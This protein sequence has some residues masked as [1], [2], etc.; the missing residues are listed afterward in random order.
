MGQA[1]CK[2]RTTKA[3]DSKSPLDRVFVRCA[4]RI[5]PSLKEEGSVLGGATQ[6]VTSSEIGYA[7]SPPR[8]I[9]ARGRSID[10]VDR[11]FHPSDWVDVN[12]EVPSPPRTSSVLT[13]SAV[14]ASLY[15]ATTPT[16]SYSN[17]KDVTPVPP[18]RRKKR[19]RGRPLPPK[20]DEIPE[21]AIGDSS[22]E[23]LHSSARSPKSGDVEDQ[24]ADAETRTNG[25]ICAEDAR[26]DGRK[27]KEIYEHK[28][29]GTGRI[30]SSDVVSGKRTSADKKTSR[31]SEPIHHHRKVLENA[32]Y[33]RFARSQSIKD[34]STPN[35]QDRRKSKELEKRITD[36]SRDDDR[37]EAN[38]RTKNYSTV[39]LPNYDELDVSRHPAKSTTRDERGAGEKMK[40]KRPVRSST[41]SL[42]AESFLSPFSEKTSVRLEDY[43]PRRGSIEHLSPYQVL[44]KLGSSENEVTDG[45]FMKY[46]PSKLEDWDLSDISNCDSTRRDSAENLPRIEIYGDAVSRPS[47]GVDVVDYSRKVETGEAE[48]TEVQISCVRRD[49]TSPLQKPETFGKASSPLPKNKQPKTDLLADQ[50]SSLRYFEVPT[51]SEVCQASSVCELASSP[52]RRQPFFL[53]EE[54]HRS[55]LGKYRQ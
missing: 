10:S 29:N 3:Q 23:P 16:S 13:N 38:T 5:Y 27:T 32:E 36:S 35:R 47:A 18:P 31:T 33:E 54:L 17:M 25:R 2:E 34:S 1:W 11:P 52:T 15:S 19:N 9:L 6:R 41:G 24:D 7:G 46:D 45:G 4:H 42:P 20:P 8:E 26:Q 28:V 49:M 12:L 39:S 44:G 21:S 50:I 48:T 40:S 37:P 14:D 51:M 30:I 22:E 43:I 53:N 55:A